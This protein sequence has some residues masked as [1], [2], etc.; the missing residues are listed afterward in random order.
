MIG[1]VEMAAVVIA[2]GLVASAVIVG[3]SLIIAAG[4]IRRRGRD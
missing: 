3:V 4:R 2:L 1:D